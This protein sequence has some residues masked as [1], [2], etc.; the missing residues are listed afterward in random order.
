MVDDEPDN[1]HLINGLLSGSYRIKAATSGAK[2]LNICAS[3]TLP[4]A[5]ILDM[6]M[7]EMDGIAVIKELKKSPP[8]SQIP[9]IMV[10]AST[11]EEDRQQCLDAG[12]SDY[13]KKPVNAE[14]LT[15]LLES[16][17]Q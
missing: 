8:Q 1:I 14:Q 3:A 11:R 12:A 9:I 16:L 17:I 7:P 6:M 15:Q 13:L 4:D 2:C 10:S 5:I